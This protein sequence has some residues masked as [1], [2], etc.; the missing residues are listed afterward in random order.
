MSFNDLMKRDRARERTRNFYRRAARTQEIDDNFI[1]KPDPRERPGDPGGDARIPKD[2]GDASVIERMARA[3]VRSGRF[4][5]DGAALDWLCNSQRG[6]F[7]VQ[8]MSS[9][10]TT[11][12]QRAVPKPP[13]APVNVSSAQLVEAAKACAVEKFGGAADVAF[14]KLAA[15]PDDEGEMFRRAHAKLRHR[16]L[17]GKSASAPTPAYNAITAKAEALRKSDPKLT[18]EQAFAKAYDGN[19]ELREAERAERYKA[20]GAPLMFEVSTTPLSIGSLDADKALE[21]INELAR[22]L[23]R[24]APW[25]TFQQCWAKI[26]SDNPELARAE[27]EQRRRE[28]GA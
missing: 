12:R 22:R 16:E 25:L 15:L 27:R 18:K 6:Q 9:H 28:L 20:I 26:Y 7:Y 24:E 19:P 21:Q 1:D 10:F 17:Y 3:L 8:R 4:E 11:K 13:A 23:N 14:A 5:D 2:N